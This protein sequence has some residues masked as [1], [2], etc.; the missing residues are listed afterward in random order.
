MRRRLADRHR[1]RLMAV[2]RAKPSA[3]GSGYGR[4]VTLRAPRR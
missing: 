3:G 1:L 4:H 2:V